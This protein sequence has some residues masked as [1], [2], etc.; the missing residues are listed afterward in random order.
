MD[1]VIAVGYRVNYKK[2]LNSEYEKFRIKQYEEYILSMYK[3]Y[4]DI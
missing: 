1:A 3:M 2:R 4:K